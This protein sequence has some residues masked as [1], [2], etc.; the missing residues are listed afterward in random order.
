MKFPPLGYL[1]FAVAFAAGLFLAPRPAR[2]ADDSWIADARAEAPTGAPGKKSMFAG[3]TGRLLVKK[4][5]VLKVAL[6]EGSSRATVIFL[7]LKDG[8]RAGD[9]E[10]LKDEPLILMHSTVEADEIVFK[11]FTGAAN[12]EIDSEELKDVIVDEGKKEEIRLIPFQ[13]TVGRFVNLSDFR[14]SC[15]Y[16]FMSGG[17]EVSKSNEW[18]R[19]VSLEYVGSSLTKTWKTAA[20]RIIVEAIHG[21]VLVRIGHPFQKV[22]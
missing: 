14:S 3:E 17:E 5:R 6:G 8:K 19:P 15:T 2:G 12:L 16:T 7:P 1:P 21:R 20:D 11:V 10:V 13:D 4:N 9:K 22:K 18:N